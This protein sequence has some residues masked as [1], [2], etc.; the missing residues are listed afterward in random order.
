M[1]SDDKMEALEIQGALERIIANQRG[2]IS[3]LARV[4]EPLKDGHAQD[5]RRFALAALAE[6]DH[7]QHCPRCHDTGRGPSGE[8]DCCEASTAIAEGIQAAHGQR[9]A[10]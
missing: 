6:T 9:Y 3:E 7:L 1:F 4:I 8:L 10:A 5:V 2:V